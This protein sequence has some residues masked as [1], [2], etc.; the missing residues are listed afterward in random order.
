MMEKTTTTKTE[1]TKAQNPTPDDE[2]DND[3]PK[4]VPSSSTRKIQH[5]RPDRLL[6]VLI[7][8]MNALCILVNMAAFFWLSSSSSSAASSSSG[9]SLW[10]PN[11]ENTGNTQHPDDDAVDDEYK[12]DQRAKN[13]QER[14]LCFL[15]VLVGFTGMIGVLGR[16][17]IPVLIATIFIPLHWLLSLLHQRL[18]CD[19]GDGD[20]NGGEQDC[21]LPLTALLVGSSIVLLWIAL[22]ARFLFAL[23]RERQQERQPHEEKTVIPFSASMTT[24]KSHHLPRNASKKSEQLQQV[25]NTSNDKEDCKLCSYIPIDVSPYLKRHG[26]EWSKNNYSNEPQTDSQVALGAPEGD[27]NWA[28]DLP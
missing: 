6:L 13:V 26:L 3:E 12:E 16:Q 27:A 17:K 22:Y 28:C 24:T 9:Q 5:C 25:C 8:V 20:K 2:D 11:K 18:D 10:F 19:G 1:A 15:G 7:L 14:V 23:V 4:P 21:Q